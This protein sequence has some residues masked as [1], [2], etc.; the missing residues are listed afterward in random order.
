MVSI[1]VEYERVRKRCFQ[2]QRLTHDRSRCPFNPQNRHS[3]A[4]GGVE[5]A[6]SGSVTKI[7]QLGTDDP[8]FGVLTNDDVGLDATTGR[9]K[10]SKEVLD[11][12]RSYLSVA[13]PTEKLARIDRVRRSVWNLEGDPQG[14]KTLLRL[15]PATEV[16]TN[17]NKGKGLVFDFDTKKANS[18]NVAGEKLMASAIKASTAITRFNHVEA[19]YTDSRSLNPLLHPC[20]TVFKTGGNAS[21]SGTSDTIKKYRRRPSQH[22]RKSQA[23]KETKEYRKPELVYREKVKQDGADGLTLKRKAE[24]VG[25]SSPKIA[26]RSENDLAVVP[27]EEPPKQV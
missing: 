6:A 19:P 24:E 25:L 20:S 26:R 22:K 13:D 21:S 8:L 10:I 2:C 15:E 9:P 5:T 7:T 11:E 17:V 27:Y 16:T 23:A 12:M 14:Q 4:T 18:Q 3:S 1:G